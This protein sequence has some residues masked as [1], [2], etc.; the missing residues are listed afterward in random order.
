LTAEDCQ[1]CGEKLVPNLLDAWSALFS[2]E[3]GGR[4]VVVN[5]PHPVVLWVNLSYSEPRAAPDVAALF[6]AATGHAAALPPLRPLRES[7]V[8]AWLQL[9]EVEPFVAGKTDAI[10]NLLDDPEAYVE[11]GSIHMRRF[12]DAVVGL[13]AR[14]DA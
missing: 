1:R 5:P 11:K 3:R 14:A 7:D 12:A 13:L 8:S 4:P 10:L 6:A 2:G 9:G